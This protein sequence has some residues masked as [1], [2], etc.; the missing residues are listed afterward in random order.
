MNWKLAYAQNSVCKDIELKTITEIE[1]SGYEI[2]D[3]TV[4]GCIET[5]LMKVGKLPDVYY[6]ENTLLTQKLE[7][8][9]L[10]YYTVVDINEE[11]SILC[12]EGIDTISDIFVNGELAK[13]VKNMFIPHTIPVNKGRNEVVVHIKPTVLEARK[14]ISPAGCNANYYSYPSLYIRKPAHQFG[15][16]IMPRIVSAGLWKNVKVVAGKSNSIDEVYIATNSASE[17]HSSLTLYFAVT[18]SDDFAQDYSISI[19]GE[20]GDSSFGKTCQLFHNCGH[21]QLGVDNA[22]LWWPKNAGK[23]NLYDVEIKL[24]H[25]DKLQDTYTFKY[26]IRTIKLNHSDITD[27]SGNGKFCF[28]VNGKEIFVLG[29][30]WVPLDALHHKDAERL[31]KALE[32]LDDINCNMVRCWGGNLYES[33]EFYDFCDS[34]GIMVWQDFTFGCATYPNDEELFNEIKKEATYHIKRLRN[35]ASLA[36]WAGD[37]ECDLAYSWIGMTRDPNVNV[38]NRNVL[39]SLVFENDYGRSYLPSSPH[40]SQRAFDTKSLLPEDHLWGP[41]DYFKGDYYNNT[42]CHFAS[43]TGY[44]AF[45]SPKSLERF[46]ENPK[47]IFNDNGVATNEYLVHAACMS[48]NADQDPYAYRIRLAYNQ[49]VTLFGRAEENFDDF[50]KQSQISQA[51]AM[52]YFVEKFRIAKPVRSGIIWWNLLDGWPQVSDAVVDYYYIKKIAYHYI[53]RSQNPICFMFG[54]PKNNQIDLHCVNDSLNTVENIPVSVTDVLNNKV[55]YEGQFTSPTDTSKKVAGIKI[56]P[57]EKKFYLIEWKIDGK[58]YKN[59]YF[60]NIIDINY[61]DY[62]SALTKSGLNQFEGF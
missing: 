45:N 32:L 57:N 8:L 11:N 21:I 24:Y 43:E 14:H 31:D 36:L 47:K 7:S 19:K 17:E 34:H 16:D 49:V 41:R 10:W 27:A 22:K 52:K 61:N 9:H 25:K 38:L 20:C 28:E 15:W 29:T 3:A 60:T 58:T 48:T 5:E 51:E 26:G 54:E 4:P 44:H 33:D 56:E 6:S 50:V 23:Q 53:K 1:N 55:V 62:I 42:F 30:N 13:S 59:H 39:R 37:N 35:H 12:F 18:L 2:L 40:V 46:L